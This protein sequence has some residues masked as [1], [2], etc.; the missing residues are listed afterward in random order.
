M[1]MIGA[2]IGLIQ[3]SFVNSKNKEIP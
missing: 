1:G 3:S 2:A